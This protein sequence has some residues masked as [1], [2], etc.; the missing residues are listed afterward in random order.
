MKG[1]REI[2]LNVKKPKAT[3]Y[4]WCKVPDGYTSIEFTKKLLNDAGI[5]VTP[6]IGFGEYG[7]G[8][9]RFALTRDVKIIE[10]AIERLKTIDI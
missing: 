10:E 3:F 1:L 2:G 4:V 5:L 7:E 9:V 6:G 8:Y